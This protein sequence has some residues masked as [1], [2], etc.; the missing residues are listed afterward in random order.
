MRG[1]AIDRRPVETHRAGIVAQR[2]AEAIDQRALAGAVGAD[3]PEPRPRV[4]LEI[5]G[6]ERR[7]AAEALREVLDL[8]ERRRHR[9]ALRR[10]S[11]LSSPTMPFGAAITNRISSSPTTS[12]LISG[13]PPNQ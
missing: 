10:V 9:R 6:I 4:H 5:D 11:I 13:W 3:Q 1:E 7:E 8:K 12:R 2:A